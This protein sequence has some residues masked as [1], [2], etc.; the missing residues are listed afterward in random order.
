MAREA[1]CDAIHPGYGFLSENADFARRCAEAGLTFVGPRPETLALFGDKAPGPGPGRA[2]RRARACR[3]PPGAT[4]LDEARGVPRRARAGR[5]G[6][7]QGG[8]RRR[9]AG[10][11]ARAPAATSWRRPSTR[12]PSEAAAAFG[13]GDLY[14]ERLL[15]RA[16]HLEVQIVGDG[17]GEVS[18]LWERE[19]SLQRQHQKLV[20]MAPAPG[21]RAGAVRDAAARAAARAPGPGGGLREPGHLRVPGRRR[22]GERRP[23]SSS[24][25]PTPAC[26]SSTPSPRRSPASTSSGSSSSWPAA[27]R[28]PTSAC[29]GRRAG[30]AGHRHAGARQ[31]GDDGRRRRRAAGAAAR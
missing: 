19:C 25:R 15:P 6:D 8:G 9:R 20:E 3:A 13:D 16:R 18:H 31:H 26:R 30:A 24:S 12:C 27:G 22:R 14:V 10:H 7:G 11:A 17:T 4:S 1:G 29:P 23:R 21:A 28:W 5:R 2:L